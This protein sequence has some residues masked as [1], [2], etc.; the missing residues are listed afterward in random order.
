MT[1]TTSVLPNANCPQVAVTDSMTI[2][3]HQN[4]SIITSTNAITMCGETFTLPDLVT[5]SNNSSIQWAD[6]TG[7]TLGTLTNATTET[8][9]F[10]PSANEI[11]NGVAQLTLTA[12]PLSG[13]TVSAT[14]TITVNLPFS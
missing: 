2:T 9:I 8:P 12:L 4:P 6:T 7:G 3:I 1:L 14:T 5:V 13:C 11:A 10:T